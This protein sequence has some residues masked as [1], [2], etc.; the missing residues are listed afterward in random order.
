M[1]DWRAARVVVTGGTGFIGAHLVRRLIA[2]GAEV[3][4]LLGEAGGVGPLA[5]EAGRFERLDADVRSGPAVRRALA[6]AAPEVVFHLA[7]VGVQEPFLP[8]EKALRVNVT[9]A[10]N[11]IRGAQT[12]RRIVFVGSSHEL[13]ERPPGGLDPISTYA[14]SKAAAWAFARML[15][16]TEAAPVVG[17]RPFQVYGPGQPATAVLSTALV[18]ARAGQDFPMTG[19]EQVRDWV[20]VDDTVD[21][22]L[23][24]AEVAGVEGEMF[25]LGAG[26][27]HSL[28]EVVER[29]FALAGASSRPR[30]G[31][32][33]YRPGEVMRLVAD[34]GPAAERLGWTARTG[35]DEGL[36][37]LVNK[38][39]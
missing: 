34:A 32:L 12:A 16:R 15:W 27:G 36:A 35:L 6:R 4:L 5:G 20:Y 37:R 17:V 23:A 31:L 2:A 9:G 22:L 18:A 21:G 28:L 10:V 1:S 19:G 8:L 11:V 3:W 33:P 39:E 26:R 30:P 24:A 29:L 7:A 13:G 25:E 14:A 38:D